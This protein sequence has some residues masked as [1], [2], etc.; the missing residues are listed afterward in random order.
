METTTI[1]NESSAIAYYY[2]SSKQSYPSFLQPV[3][4]PVLPPTPWAYADAPHGMCRFRTTASRRRPLPS[5]DRPAYAALHFIRC[6]K[7][8]AEP[9]DYLALPFLGNVLPSNSAFDGAM[10]CRDTCDIAR[11]SSS[12]GHQKLP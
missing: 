12:P 6:V 4:V 3:R 2:C 10:Q 11:R 1:Q 9:S 8:L 5:Q 7:F